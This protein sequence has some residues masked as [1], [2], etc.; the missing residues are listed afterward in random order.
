MYNTKYIL[1][2]IFSDTK[3]SLYK[4]YFIMS[5]FYL[6]SSHNLNIISK[7]YVINNLSP[8]LLV[9]NYFPHKEIYIVLI[10]HL[11]DFCGAY[12]TQWNKVPKNN[13]DLYF[14]VTSCP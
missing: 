1:K 11:F 14:T 3:Q 5:C 9:I 8:K 4:K 2:N 7:H 10:G 12:S 13:N 6:L